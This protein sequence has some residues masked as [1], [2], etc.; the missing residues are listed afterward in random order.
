[1]DSSIE[2]DQGRR[3]SGCYGG[4][5]AAEE[6]EHLVLVLKQLKRIGL[7]FLTGFCTQLFPWAAQQNPLLRNLQ[8]KRTGLMIPG[9][10]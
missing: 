4:L 10:N 1:M 6:A 5:P 3:A 8:L 2:G 9:Q 7:Q